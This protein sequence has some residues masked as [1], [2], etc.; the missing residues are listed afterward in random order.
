VLGPGDNLLPDVKRLRRLAST[1][2]KQS[3]SRHQ[4][5]RSPARRSARPAAG[6]SKEGDG[7]M[8]DRI[9]LTA[10]DGIADVR[11]YHAAEMSALDPALFRAI[12][13]DRRATQG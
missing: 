2:S 12:A 3:Y 5:L 11:L 7:G 13:R 1:L 10:T 4:A 9:R 6:Q 8:E